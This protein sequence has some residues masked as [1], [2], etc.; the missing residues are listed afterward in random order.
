M[1]TASYC[2]LTDGADGGQLVADT[3]GEERKGC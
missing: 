3:D 2:R 1:V